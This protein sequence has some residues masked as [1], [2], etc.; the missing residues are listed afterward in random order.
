MKKTLTILILFFLAC[1]NPGDFEKNN[2]SHPTAKLKPLADTNTIPQQK[3]TGNFFIPL[4]EQGKA[5]E[6]QE[7]KKLRQKILTKWH[8]YI[9]KNYN[10][11]RKWAVKNLQTDLDTIIF[12][13]FGG[14]DLPTT[15]SF[16]PN[17][18]KIFLLGLENCGKLLDSEEPNPEILQNYYQA[19]DQTLET[20]Y[21]L[22]YFKTLKMK[23]DFRQENFNG[24][25]HLLSFFAS[26]LTEINRI[27]YFL[28]DKNGE[29]TFTDSFSPLDKRIKGIKISCTKTNGQP[30]EV[31]YLQINLADEN[32][33]DYPELFCFINKQGKF[34]TFLKSA[35]YLLQTD[36]FRHLKNFIVSQSPKIIQ[37]D[38]GFD[39][40]F[41]VSKNYNVSVFGIYLKPGKP[42]EK[43]LQPEL[44]E[45]TKNNT[46]LPFVFGYNKIKNSLVILLAQKQQDTTT[47]PFYA[48]QFAMRWDKIPPGDTVFKVLPH[49][50]YYFDEGYY[51]Y[52]SGRCA[53]PQEC[54]PILKKAAEL[55]YKDAFV[56]KFLKNSKII[57]SQKNISE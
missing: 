46:P 34:T 56:I 25:V 11:Q 45:L 2:L 29:T 12:Y 8:E 5:F 37:D 31:Y 43:Y 17:A 10:I 54:L 21:K 50:D 35:S 9:I 20:F 30:L 48:V 40:N 41:L 16:F 1:S 49:V 42:F 52:I 57:V 24:T 47:Y 55:N 36:D 4:L 39:Y 51:K 32:I 27:S 22:G 44:F 19:L 3:E 7:T 14:P 6:N 23:Y 53:S 33:C 15:L 38:S 28:L 18:K 26:Q 13:P